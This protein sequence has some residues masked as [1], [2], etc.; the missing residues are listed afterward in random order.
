MANHADLTGESRWTPPA[1]RAHAP[2]AETVVTSEETAVSALL[3]QHPDA[4]VNAINAR[5]LFFPLRAW[6]PIKG[7]RHLWGRSPF[8][9]VPPSA[10]GAIFPGGEPPRQQ[11]GAHVSATL[12][13]DPPV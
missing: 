13:A 11:G 3:M 12:V 1:Q 4:F 5:G 8:D 6:V 7:P 10:R 2:S 9:V